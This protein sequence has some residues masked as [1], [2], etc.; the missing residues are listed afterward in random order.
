MRPAKSRPSYIINYIG[1]KEKLVDSIWK[2]TPDG[3]S[4]VLDAFFGSAVVAYMY[5]RPGASR[6]SAVHA[7]TRRP[8]VVQLGSSAG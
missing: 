3:G 4:S 2:H 5:K 8:L 1:S 7:E 6:Q